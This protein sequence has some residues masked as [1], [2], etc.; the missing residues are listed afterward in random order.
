MNKRDKFIE[1]AKKKIDIIQAKGKVI[2]RV[3]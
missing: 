3:K 1:D 2:L